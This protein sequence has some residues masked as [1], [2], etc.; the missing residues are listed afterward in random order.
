[1]AILQEV[2]GRPCPRRALEVPGRARK[3]GSPL[4][5]N[6]VR[7]STLYHCGTVPE[8]CRLSVV[9]GIMPRMAD[10]TLVATDLFPDGTGVGAY[11]RSAWP[12]GTRPQTGSA[13]KGD[14]VGSATASGGQIAFTGLAAD[15]QYVAAAQVNGVW[16]VIGFTTMTRASTFEEVS[17][18]ADAALLLGESASLRAPWTV[19]EEHGAVGDGSTDDTAAL[20][21]ALA[22]GKHVV[23]TPGATYLHRRCLYMRTAGQ[24][25]DG[26][27]ATLKRAAQ[28]VTTTATTI[29]QGVTTAITVASTAGFSVGD[30]IVVEKSGTFSTNANTISSIVGSVITVSAPFDTSLSGTT[31]VRHGWNQ[32]VPYAADQRVTN[33]VLDGNVASWS[34][35]R[36]QHTVAL[37]S[38][39]NAP[40]LVVDHCR[41]VNQY[42]DALTGAASGQT[43]AFND[44]EDCKGRG[45]VFA[46]NAGAPTDIGTRFVYNRLVNTNG[47]TAVGGNDG[48]GAIDFSQGGPNTLIHGNYIDGGVDG[49][50]S[51][52]SSQ[53]GGVTITANE[54]WNLT[55]KG[56]DGDGSS[57]L[58]VLNV[59][60]ADNRF[61]GCGI[62]VNRVGST[63]L[64]KNWNIHDNTIIGAGIKLYSVVDVNLHDNI[65]SRAALPT[66]K[67]TELTATAVVGG[68]SF[69]ATTYYYKIAAYNANGTTAG[70]A[71][72]SAAVAANGS[73]LLTWQPIPGATGYKV[74]RATSSNG[75]NGATSLVTTI[76]SATTASYT[77][78][79]AATTTGAC[80]SS[81]TTKDTTHIL[82]ECGASGGS[83]TGKIAGNLLTAGGY[84]IKLNYVGA[85]L[86]IRDNILNGQYE[87]GIFNG[88]NTNT[89]VRIKGNDITADSTAHTSNYFGI[90]TTGTDEVTDNSIKVP[91]AL[92]SYG[93]YMTSSSGG[94][95]VK[96]NK[97]IT[98]SGVAIWVNSGVVS[99]TVVGNTTDN[100]IIDSGTN[101]VKFGNTY[102]PAPVTGAATLV[103]GTV[104]VGGL[105]IQ[106]GDKV[107]LTRFTPGGTPG[108]L[109]VGTITQG[110]GGSFVIN[111]SDAADT[112]VVN[113]QIVH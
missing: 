21:A 52:R 15:T 83:C 33:L 75:Q 98:T 65:V 39:S 113:W 58:D 43:F 99:A 16:Q 103:A 19:P 57:A 66:L 64:S 79:G 6:F 54:F 90:V 92:G 89:F 2:S 97:S 51:L 61:Y 53:N 38:F 101:T 84:G 34:W 86:T 3:L 110:P 46:G 93:I 24:M 91:S 71:E 23:L 26:R 77:D 1:M 96:N 36:W 44:V 12:A 76:A 7:C 63:G 22:T 11:L 42:G 81:D 40:R 45:M 69:S 9:V 30:E 49:I 29:T 112:S 50:G 17:A 28:A 67:A 55:G 41:I 106:T 80:P 109:S 59:T 31:N 14:V 32:L 74:Y 20:E 10:T 4:W 94:M 102:G 70:S 73:V 78:T 18:T 68:G 87:S 108:H 5:T 62:S 35:G 37:Q 25:L 8:Y 13:P 27:G 111:S 72:V 88:Y 82:I 60:I 48:T 107:L 56:I 95:I 47:D 100:Y 105:D 104:T 85:G